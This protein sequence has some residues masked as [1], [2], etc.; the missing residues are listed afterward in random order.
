MSYMRRYVFVICKRLKANLVYG[1]D[2]VEAVGRDA[3]DR[4]R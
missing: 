3:L 4:D 2:R 1:L